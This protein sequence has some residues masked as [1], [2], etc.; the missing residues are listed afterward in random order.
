M[1]MEIPSDEEPPFLDILSFHNPKFTDVL[2]YEG[3]RRQGNMS[4]SS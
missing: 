3:D 2:G 4:F 1:E